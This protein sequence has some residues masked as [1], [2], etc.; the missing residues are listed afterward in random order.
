MNNLIVNI[1]SQDKN[2]SDTTK[3]SQNYLEK[4]D[5]ANCIRMKTTKSQPYRTA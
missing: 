4:I 3:K 5:Q 2:N 1:L